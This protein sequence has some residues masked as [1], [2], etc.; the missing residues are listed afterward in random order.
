MG[1][2]AFLELELDKDAGADRFVSFALKS[3]QAGKKSSGKGT[4]LATLRTS[5]LMNLLLA[6]ST[7]R[8]CIVSQ[9]LKNNIF[10]FIPI[11]QSAIIL[12]KH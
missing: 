8:F 4:R 6:T 11:P 9:R 7:K 12:V 2:K 5:L 10:Y 1:R 3:H